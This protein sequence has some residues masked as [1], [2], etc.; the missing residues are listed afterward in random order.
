MEGP[1]SQH[2]VEARFALHLGDRDPYAVVDDAFLPLCVTR[3]GGPDAE[4]PAAGQAL[5]LTGAEVSAVIREG[6]ALHVRVFNPT[7]D[8]TS[9][10]IAGRQGWLLDLRGR[11]LRPFEE[12]FELR[13]WEIATASLT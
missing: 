4:G 13:P 10:T 2:A 12:R 1:Q 6:E 9:V 11:P 8:P 5:S 3:G 7:P